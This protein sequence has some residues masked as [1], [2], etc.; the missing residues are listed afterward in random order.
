MKHVKDVVN[1]RRAMQ[2]LKLRKMFEKKVR[3]VKWTD[4]KKYSKSHEQTDEE[5]E[6][7]GEREREENGRPI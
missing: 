1:N 7:H 4:N 3:N 5:E 6:K 2:K